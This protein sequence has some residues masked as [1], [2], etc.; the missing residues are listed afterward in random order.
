[1]K[2]VPIKK[3]PYDIFKEMMNDP[4]ISKEKKKQLMNERYLNDKYNFRCL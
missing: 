4:G 3:L 1:M 2:F